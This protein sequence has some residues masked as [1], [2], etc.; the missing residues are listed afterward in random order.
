MTDAVADDDEGDGDFDPR[1]KK[2]KSKG[3]QKEAPLSTTAEHA[4]GLH[5][6]E[7]DYD[8]LLAAAFDGSLSGTGSAQG[9]TAFAASSSQA[10]GGFAFD[11]VFAL[12]EDVGG[13]DIGDELAQ[14]LGEGWGGSTQYDCGLLSGTFS[15]IL[16][17]ATTRP[18]AA[19]DGRE[20]TVLN[21]NFDQGLGDDFQF[22][23]HPQAEMQPAEMEDRGR[24]DQRLFLH[25][26]TVRPGSLP[27]TGPVVVPLGSEAHSDPAANAEVQAAKPVQRKAKRVRLLL[28]SRTELTDD[29]LKVISLSSNRGPELT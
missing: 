4:R 5:T 12:P 6:L 2:A 15:A 14:E 13:A 10:D 29:E 24:N 21:V 17:F 26:L 25:F 19:G 8:H 20:V 16:T 9:P 22:D 23:V 3:K 28:D 1:S 7:E 27:P 11:D 18:V